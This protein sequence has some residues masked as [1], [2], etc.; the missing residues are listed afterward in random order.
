MQILLNAR[1]RNTKHIPEGTLMN[2][3]KIPKVLNSTFACVCRFETV[4]EKMHA[5]VSRDFIEMRL[6]EC[7]WLQPIIRRTRLSVRY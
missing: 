5:R 6:T 2:Q 1:E 7:Q 3:N 4:Y